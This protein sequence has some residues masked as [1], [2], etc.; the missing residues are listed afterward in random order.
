MYH[1]LS[2]LTYSSMDMSH[3]KSMINMSM[4][5]Y[6]YYTLLHNR[7]GHSR[8]GM[9]N[10]TLSPQLCHRLCVRV[11]IESLLSIEMILSQETASGSSFVNIFPSLVRTHKRDSPNVRMITN[12]VDSIMLSMNYINDTWWTA[13]LRQHIHKHHTSP[14][15]S[16]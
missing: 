7:H 8:L 4:L 16:L 9:R 13:S 12:E 2:P 3:I 6:C 1:T 10:V 15:V 5:Q 14:R 11:E